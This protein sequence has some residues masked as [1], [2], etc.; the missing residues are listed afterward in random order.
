MFI[1]LL[2]DIV[3]E[4][5]VMKT[6]RYLLKFVLAAG[7]MT[8]G[9]N[10]GE[11]GYSNIA[12][13]EIIEETVEAVGEYHMGDNETPTQAKEGALA[14]AKRIAAEKV[15]TY[16]ESNTNVEDFIVLKD[17]IKTYTNARMRV[18]TQDYKFTGEE[19][20]LCKA[21]ITATVKIDT[22]LLKNPPP[23][24][25]DDNK[26]TSHNPSP[27]FDNVSPASSG[28][29]IV[30]LSDGR[31]KAIGEYRMG[32]N[33][34]EEQAKKFALQNAIDNAAITAGVQVTNF[35]KVNNYMVTDDQIEMYS[36]SI[37]KVQD[38]QDSIE[39]YVCRVTI[40]AEVNL[41]ENAMKAY[42]DKIAPKPVIEP[43]PVPVNVK[44]IKSTEQEKTVQPTKPV[45]TVRS[46]TPSTPSPSVITN[47]AEYIERGSHVYLIV[48]GLNLDYN[49]AD[50]WCKEHGGHLVYIE[51]EDEQKF[52]QHN[53]LPKGDKNCYWI[54]GQR[55][56]NLKK[57]YW[58]PERKKTIS[59]TNWAKGQPDNFTKNE[60]VLMMY[61]RSNP[62]APNYDGQWNDI[63]VDGEC[64]G[65][66]F[67]GKQN[68][69]FICEWDSKAAV[70]D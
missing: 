42:F 13:A 35:T 48:D 60:S 22:E 5:R 51:S 52:I 10:A 31:V 19:G 65:E 64:K 21:F 69:G 30:L 66:A 53:V 56:D 47:K 16:V 67:F 54:G 7:L 27:A 58:G 61:K 1:V 33:D 59:Y 38:Y 6:K 14:D 20:R 15:M 11:F 50:Q 32:G 57:W 68:F 36:K 41:D 49:Q 37:V 28:S 9:L 23:A 25:Q 43:D 29:K 2:R 55:G 12:Y 40:V 4:V 70:R 46:V 34:K 24:L 62:N 17:K 8:M 44:P 26:P 63:G 18:L 3:S 45:E 39:N